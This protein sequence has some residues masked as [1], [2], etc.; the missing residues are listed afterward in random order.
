MHALHPMLN[1]AIK[2]A[3]RA[4]S[5][6]SRAARDIESLIVTTKR[7]ADFVTEIDKAAEEVIIEVIKKAYPEHAIL[8]EESGVT[9]RSDYVWIID[10]IDGTTNFIHGLPHYAIS[11]ALQF[12]GQIT[13]AVI[14]DP[15]KNELF[16]ATR[17]RGAFMNE[18]R[19]RV[20]KR[21]NM[22]ETLIA[23]G[24]PFRDSDDLESYLRVFRNVSTKTAGLRRGGA[25]ALDMAYVA[26]GRL[27]AY[28]EKGI[29][30]WDIAAGSLLVLEAGGLVSDMEGEGD[31][32]EKGHVI[33]GTP[34]IFAQLLPLVQTQLKDS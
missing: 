9:G 5:V 15:A 10:P 30:A 12:K 18:Q 21:T 26:A 19:I 29:K 24:F 32:L 14:F 31:Y 27:D 16:T 34:K 23:T 7:P 33:C 13:Q 3:R 20:T 22:R 25:A 1:I 8:A 11:I 28:W 6:V 17:G 2:A 4:G